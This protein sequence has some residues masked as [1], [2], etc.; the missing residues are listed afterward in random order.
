MA[1]RLSIASKALTRRYLPP[2][3]AGP[4]VK[5][6]RFNVLLALGRMDSDF[7]TLVLTRSADL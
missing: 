3:K 6:P 7:G 2:Q 5:F 1:W 4:E